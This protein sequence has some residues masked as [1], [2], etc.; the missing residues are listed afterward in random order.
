MTVAP[1]VR[2]SSGIIGNADLALLKRLR[3]V[4]R[5]GARGQYPGQRRSPRSARSPELA[6][7]R[8]YAPG[9]DIR[10]IDWRAFGRLEKL[11]VRL[12]VAEEEAAVNVVV[13]ASQSMALGSPAKWPAARRLAEAVARLGLSAMDRVAVGPLDRPARW[14]PHVRLDGGTARLLACLAGIEPGGGGGPDDLARLPALR[15]GLTVVISDFLTEQDWG[16][17]LL[18][19]GRAG[20]DVVLWQVLS[21]EEERPDLSGD[22]RLRDVESGRLREITVTPRVVQDYLRALDELRQ[23]LANEAGAAGGR[24]LYTRSDDD[25]ETSMR[26]GLRAGV[27]RRA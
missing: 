9:D 26:A 7:F 16:P 18:A 22:L 20:Q 19:L 25:L 11:M 21:P 1:T 23:K 10:Q 2:P 27:V 3:L 8:P 17:A 15:P 12:Y 5:Q 6:D 14:T 24:F 13:D 4:H